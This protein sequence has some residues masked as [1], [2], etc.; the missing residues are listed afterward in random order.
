MNLNNIIQEAIESFIKESP[1]NIRDKNDRYI[2]Y[3]YPG[4]YPF[5]VNSENNE[6]F[7]G[8]ET[9][10]HGDEKKDIGNGHVAYLRNEPFHYQGRLFTKQKVVTFWDYP[11]K[12]EIYEI[13]NQIK[14]KTGINFWDGQW[15]IEIHKY[16][17]D[18][19]KYDRNYIPI[20][21]FV[22]SQNVSAADRQAHLLSPLEKQKREVPQGVGS[23]RYGEKMP[24]QY[25]QAL[26]KSE[27]EVP[28]EEWTED[29]IYDLFEERD[30]IMR[31]TI[32]D[33]MEKPDNYRQPWRVVPFG[34]LKKIWEDAARTGVV[35]DEKGLQAIQD[36]MIRNLLKL[37][38]N[39]E[40]M[41]H[42]ASFPDEQ[43]FE[44]AGTTKEEFEKKIW[45]NWGNKYFE[46]PNGQLRISDYGLDPLWKYA[47][48]LISVDDPIKK[49]Q[50]IDQMLNVV[51]MRS[52][53]AENFIEGGSNSLTQLFNGEREWE[54]HRPM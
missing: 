40:L 12:E 51:H 33:A 13:L 31:D 41:G 37:D 38:V 26:V 28:L 16:D 7:I 6:V 34:R 20:Q 21:Q 9:E 5:A 19:G 50:Y 22:G 32:R 18:T 39:T 23:R 10:G 45:E 42:K 25:R 2:D 48:Q 53:L 3:R 1:D 17:D 46:L 29:Q 44:D 47:E 8:D 24:L 54:V 30:E 14:S 4:T 36:R 27:S 49:I 35:R 52:D 43:E 15:Q 11:S